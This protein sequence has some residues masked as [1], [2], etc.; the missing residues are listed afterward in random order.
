MTHHAKDRAPIERD[1]L[2]RARE[3]R[4]A[5]A[6]LYAALVEHHGPAPRTDI[7][8]ELVRAAGTRRAW[9]SRT[10]GRELDPSPPASA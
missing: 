4:A 6:K 2:V 7:A 5:S 9:G 3:G 1:D 10:R 8:E